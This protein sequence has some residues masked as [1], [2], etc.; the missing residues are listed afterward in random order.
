[1]KIFFI[2]FFIF[3]NGSVLAKS[4]FETSF[5]EINFISNDVEDDKNKK[6][7]EIKFKSLNSIFDNILIQDDFNK[8]KREI[9]EDFINFF[10]KNIIVDEEKIINNSY[11]SKI[12]VNFDKKKII[13]YLRQKE[14][15]YVEYI[16]DSFFTII[17]ED[18]KINKNFLSKKN[19]H[20]KYLLEN[21]IKYNFFALPKLDIND[22]YLLSI[23]DID[24]KN[25]NKINTFIN[26]Y[27][28]QNTVIIKSQEV[29]NKIKYSIFIYKDNSF[30]EIKNFELN[31]INHSLLFDELKEEI[32][33]SWKKFNYIQNSHIHKIS[34]TVNYFNLL[35]L[36]QIK[37]NLNN[38]SIISNIDLKNISYKSS[39]YDIIYFGEKKILPKIFDL[40][41][42]KINL[43]N[44]T[45]RIYLK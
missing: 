7:T 43:D 11:Y 29:N 9:N 26:K 10:I 38:I 12:K 37:L 8:I 36:K 14:L 3:Y 32:I 27:K 21:I 4:L 15:S 30:H 40:N 42:L 18:Y 17:Y 24:N 22:R 44:E 13:N 5:Y 20:Y 23:K 19:K 25:Y 28:Y 41:G 35:E 2:I 33:N 45:C 16:P 1:M 6:I 39:I 31:N 34:C